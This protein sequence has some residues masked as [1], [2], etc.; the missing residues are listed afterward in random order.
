MNRIEKAE[1]GRAV[2]GCLGNK[3]L[4]AE[5]SCPG[6]LGPHSSS[7]PPRV[8]PLQRVRLG[9]VG[10]RGTPAGALRPLRPGLYLLA[11]AVFLSIADPFSTPSVISN[12]VTASLESIHQSRKEPGLTPMKK[13]AI[14]ASQGRAGVPACRFTGHPGVIRF[15]REGTACADQWESLPT[16]TLKVRSWVTLAFRLQNNDNFS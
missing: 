10:E 14:C 7:S 6:I 4:S 11:L 3:D 9:L 13:N 2:E 5:H 16:P 8:R 1:W 15:I 12:N